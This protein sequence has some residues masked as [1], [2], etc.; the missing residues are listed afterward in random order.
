MDSTTVFSLKNNITLNGR[1]IIQSVLGQGGFGITYLAKDK[2]FEKAVAIKEFFPYGLVV[3]DFNSSQVTISN[4]LGVRELFE[5]EKNKFLKEAQVMVKFRKDD[6]ITEVT[7]FFEANNTAYIVM[8][9][10]D[11]M[12]LREYVGKYGSVPPQKI[13]SGWM[14]TLMNSLS[15]MHQAGMIHRDI[16]PDNIMVL[17]DGTVKLMDFGASRCFENMGSKGLT[18]IVKRC[19]SP[20]EQYQ[21]GSRQGPYTDIYALCATIYMCITGVNPPASIERVTMDSLRTPSQCEISIPVNIEKVLLKGMEVLPQNRYQTIAEMYEELYDT[22]KQT[23]EYDFSIYRSQKLKD[24]TVVDGRYII[25]YSMG[26]NEF[27]FYYHAK[28]IQTGK[29]IILKE[30]FIRNHADRNAEQYD[31]VV[32][33]SN[34]G[35]VEAVK[36][37]VW[38]DCQY[39]QTVEKHPGFVAVLDCF[40]ANNTVYMVLEDY[41]GITLETYLR[42]GAMY[43]YPLDFVDQTILMPVNGVQKISVHEV[44]SRI[45]PMI[46]GLSKF[47]DV[48]WIVEDI[49]PNNI[50]ITSDG[51]MK[52]IP[53]EEESITFREMLREFQPNSEWRPPK[54][55]TPWELYESGHHKMWY[56]DVYAAAAVIYFCITGEVPPDAL[57]RKRSREELLIPPYRYGVAITVPQE[58]A[59]LKAMSVDREYRYQTMEEFYQALYKQ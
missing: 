20:I 9:Y 38:K 21:R 24:G 42:G 17:K 52:L 39:L 6:G 54:G 11:G 45:W 57:D 32:S 10:I 33:Y 37:K 14:K 58:Q 1:Y 43:G 23:S 48:G 49:T 41:Q 50:I 16:S 46:E 8:E 13:V 34:D 19:Y 36:R 27:M 56:T 44:L 2:L 51:Y 30:V 53:I 55:Y 29:S 35:L 47:H 31:Y 7:D 28:D 59:I 40:V 5:T 4:E 3:R 15:Q 25:D 26:Y 22:D 12:T 18:T